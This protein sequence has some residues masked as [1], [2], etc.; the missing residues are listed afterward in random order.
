[1]GARKMWGIFAVLCAI[2]AAIVYKEWSASKAQMTVEFSKF[3][4]QY[5]TIWLG[6]MMADWLQGPY[7]YALYASYGFSKAEIG[8]LFIM[9]FGA[10]MVLGTIVGALADKYGRKAC[11]VAFC[12]F[13]ALSC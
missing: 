13:Y 10:S 11:C 5:V 4:R 1:M 9:G 3:Q 2:C 6:M 12:V 8:E 7:V